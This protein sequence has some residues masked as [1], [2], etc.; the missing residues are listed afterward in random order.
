MLYSIRSKSWRRPWSHNG[1]LS[2][3]TPKRHRGRW[4][5]D[6]DDDDDSDVDDDLD[7]KELERNHDEREDDSDGDIDDWDGALL[8]GGARPFDTTN[9]A[10]LV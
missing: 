7:D 5:N 1:S 3:L 9:S 2:T 8:L 10:A 6:G 4:L